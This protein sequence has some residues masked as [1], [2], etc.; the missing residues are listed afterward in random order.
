MSDKRFVDTNILVYA[1]DRTSGPKHQRAKAIVE[2]L[3]N[4]GGGVLSTQVLQELC[5]NLRRRVDPPLPTDEIRRLI[6]DYMSWE[7]VANTAESVVEALDLEAR[8]R[9]SFWDALILQSALHCGATILYSEDMAAGQKYGAVQVI[10]PLI[11]S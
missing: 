3:W 1:H 4:C 10:N 9:T 5:V 6:R 8:Y 11:A 7:I 2:E